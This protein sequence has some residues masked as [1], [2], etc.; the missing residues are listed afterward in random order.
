MIT[1]KKKPDQL[2]MERYGSATILRLALLKQTEPDE[3]EQLMPLVRCKDFICDVYWSSLGKIDI[4]FYGMKWQGKKDKPDWEQ[5]NLLVNF[6][7]K[8]MC[9]YFTEN[10]KYI[11]EIEEA[12][13]I[14]STTLL[15]V[16]ELN[17]ILLGNKKWLTNLVYLSLY[18]FLIRLMGVDK[19]ISDNWIEEIQKKK[20]TIDGKFLSTISKEVLERI[21]SDL[22]LLESEKWCGFEI[23]PETIYTIHHNSGFVSVF[24]YHD[25]MSPIKV[26][27]NFH[28]QEAHKRGL[29][30]YT[31]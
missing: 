8:E 7:N 2:M 29:E 4:S 19:I 22:S 25:E 14:P 20:E 28:W 23:K 31:K 1:L 27:E 16:D 6:P 5:V 30:L 9:V 13:D 17:V 3:F 18:V 12:N 21:F 24:G 10:L 11:W 26:K 15:V